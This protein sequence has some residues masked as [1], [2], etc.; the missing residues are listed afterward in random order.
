[1]HLNIV[2]D[3]KKGVRLLSM[4]VNLTRDGLV[5][6]TQRR[7]KVIQCSK[8]SLV[9]DYTV[10]PSTYLF[11]VHIQRSIILPVRKMTKMLAIQKL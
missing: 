10:K 11:F 9:F 2:S 5:I 8:F 6:L 1:M 3:T 4:M 7:N